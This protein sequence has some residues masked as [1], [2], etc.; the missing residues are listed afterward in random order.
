ME[1]LTY[2]YILISE[3]A[4]APT[5]FGHQDLH[6]LILEPPIE[7]PMRFKHSATLPAPKLQMFAQSS[8][9]NVFRVITARPCLQCLSVAACFPLLWPKAAQGKEAFLWPIL[10]RHNASPRADRSGTQGRSLKKTPWDKHCMQLAARFPPQPGPTAYGWCHP[11]RAEP[12]HIHH[13][14]RQF[15]PRHSHRS[16]SSS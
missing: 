4:I 13:Q 6:I 9:Q 12:P 15:S 1:S 2:R 14:S 10:A 11:R 3:N 5:P 16:I 8:P 7:H